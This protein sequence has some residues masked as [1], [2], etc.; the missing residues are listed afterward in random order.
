MDD[1]IIGFDGATGKTRDLSNEL[2]GF[3]RVLYNVTKAVLNAMTK[4]LIEAAVNKLFGK[5][6][7]LDIG[8]AFGLAK[9]GIVPNYAEGGSVDGI[10]K[11]IQKE[12]SQNGGIDPV[13]AVLTPGERVLT[14]AQN[15]KFEALKLQRFL[16]PTAIM[17]EEMAYRKIRN[18]AMGGVVGSSADSS[19]QINNTYAKEQP[20]NSTTINVPVTVENNGNSND[21]QIDASSLQNAVRSAVLT[22]IQRQQRIGGLLRK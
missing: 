5:G 13:L 3:E 21:S 22:E 12:R 6:G 7:W 19:I 2:R 8:K 14:V 18:Y 17:P 15:R 10:G 4:I 20:S 16:E 9:G 11:A 1:L